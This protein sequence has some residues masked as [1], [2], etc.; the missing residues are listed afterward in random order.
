MDEESER[1]WF[2]T[3]WY[4]SAGV[5]RERKLLFSVILEQSRR[6]KLR[7]SNEI[8]AIAPKERTIG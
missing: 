7:D 5:S 3:L 2:S 8:A 4:F 1:A 6:N